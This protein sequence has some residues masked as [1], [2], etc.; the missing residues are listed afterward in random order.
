MNEVDK[1]LS[2]LKKRR[3]IN[4]WIDQP[5]MKGGDRWRKGVD[6]AVSQTEIAILLINN[7]SLT[8]NFIDQYEVDPLL[9]AQTTRSVKIIP[10]LL[11]L[12]DLPK[13]LADL[14]FVNDKQPV[15]ELR[16]ARRDKI[17]LKVVEEI[18]SGFLSL[19]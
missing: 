18:K 10:V 14:Q 5:K 12:A 8:S 13:K 1:A 16:I 11:S 6:D 2:T 9:K 17:W 19:R 4:L 7:N 3:A 15:R